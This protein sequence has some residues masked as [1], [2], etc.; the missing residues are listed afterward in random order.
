MKFFKNYNLFFLSAFIMFYASSA[1]INKPKL[2]N[3]DSLINSI[4]D[5][6]SLHY[7][8]PEKAV[9]ISVYLQSQLKKNAY[10]GL[11]S[12]PQKRAEKIQQD[13]NSVHHDPHLRLKFDTDFVSQKIYKPTSE[14]IKQAKRYWKENNYMFKRAEVL[15]GNIDYLPLNLFVDDIEA[16]KPTITA[17]F[18]FLYHTTAL[19]IDLRENMGGS[20]EMVSQIES[21]FLKKRPP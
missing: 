12:N 5:S 3:I 21:Y 9:S 14:D 15:P 13:I 18:K 7:I 17:A 11:L 20:P 6:L 8:F 16:A 10:T 2:V 4:S 19:I 1:Q